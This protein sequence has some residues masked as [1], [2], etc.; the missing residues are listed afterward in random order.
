M[1]VCRPVEL[2]VTDPSAASGRRSLSP[3]CWHPV[4]Q[5]GW[6]RPA[7]SA[8]SSA[9]AFEQA[10]Y[11]S[12]SP[13][14][15]CPAGVSITARSAG[16]PNEIDAASATPSRARFAC[17][18]AGSGCRISNL[19]SAQPASG[20]SN[21]ALR[22]GR[23]HSMSEGTAPLS[24][25]VPSTGTVINHSRSPRVTVLISPIGAS[26]AVGH[27]SR[28]SVRSR[29]GPRQR[30][31]EGDHSPEPI[32]QRRSSVKALYVPPANCNR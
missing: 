20:K 22:C 31:Q 19:A 32:R 2:V 1:L 18:R 5:A 3:R 8:R 16:L 26:M 24:N 15:R 13:M 25:G 6:Q 17:T 23:R 29:L 7:T 27:A 21:A 10:G 28:S 11:C 4:A 30:L 14:T 9:T 12:N